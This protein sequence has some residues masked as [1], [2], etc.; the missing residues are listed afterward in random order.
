MNLISLPGGEDN[1]TYNEMAAANLVRHYSFLNSLIKAALRMGTCDVSQSLIRTLNSHA[2]AAL[3]DTAG[4]YRKGNVTVAGLTFPPP[5]NEVPVLMDSLVSQLNAK[6]AL[7]VDVSAVAAFALWRI[8]R[9]H[10]FA[11]GNGRTARAV[12]YYILCARSGGWLPGTVMLPEAL[13]REPL[14]TKYVEALK[15]ADDGDLD[16]LTGLIRL[17]IVKQI[18]GIDG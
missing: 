11:N 1:P 17:E 18:G 3:H 7:D 9:I 16:P 2:V 12:C 4:D 14:H 5:A 10:P 8:N 6:N 15:K 13:R